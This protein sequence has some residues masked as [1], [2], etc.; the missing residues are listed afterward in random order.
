MHHQVR[1]AMPA[2]EGESVFLRWLI[3]R[4]LHLGEVLREHH[5]ALQ[6]VGPRVG[7]AGKVDGCTA[8]PECL[9]AV[10]AAC[11]RGGEVGHR[12]GVSSL[13]A[14]QYAK[15][16]HLRSEEHTSELQ[17]LMRIPFAVVFLKKNRS[18]T[19]LTLSQP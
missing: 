13:G 2:V 17:S 19:R 8:R 18:N 11:C 16:K 15:L 1:L 9:P 5:A 14:E 12:R 4:T 7:T 3:A 10:V 6:F